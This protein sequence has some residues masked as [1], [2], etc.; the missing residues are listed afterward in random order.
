MASENMGTLGQ[1]VRLERAM[2]M[3]FDVINTKN[4][5]RIEVPGI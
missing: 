2:L 4:A 5:L 3:T 1:A